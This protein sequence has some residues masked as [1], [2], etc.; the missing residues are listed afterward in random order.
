MN[1]MTVRA[2]DSL[3]DDL[4]KQAKELGLTRNALVLVI[5]NE[6]VAQKERTKIVEYNEN[7]KVVKEMWQ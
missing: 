2:P 3:M 7:D 1:I 6:W 4:K 5:L